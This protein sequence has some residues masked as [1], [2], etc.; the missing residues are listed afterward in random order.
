ML[1][2][3]AIAILENLSSSDLPDYDKNATFKQIITPLEAENASKN[4]KDNAIAEAENARI[5]EGMS[6]MLRERLAKLA[7]ENKKLK[8]DVSNALDE[9]KKSMAHLSRARDA[10][11]KME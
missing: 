11:N 9:V 3:S 4:K 6:T 10:D 1:R 7:A 5:K 2:D 8:S